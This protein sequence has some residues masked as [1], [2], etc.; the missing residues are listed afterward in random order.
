MSP[1]KKPPIA[2]PIVTQKLPRYLT[3]EAIDN[4]NKDRRDQRFD[5]LGKEPLIKFLTDLNLLDYAEQAAV[6]QMDLFQ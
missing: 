5:I 2:Q 3:K 4:S 1:V 6:P